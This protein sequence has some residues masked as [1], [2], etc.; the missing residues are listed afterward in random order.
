MKTKLLFICVMTILMIGTSGCNNWACENLGLFCSDSSTPP[1]EFNTGKDISSAQSIVGKS[2]K[3]IKNATGDISKETQAIKKE[4]DQTKGKIPAA[5]KKEI[6]THLDKINKSSNTISEKTQDINKSVA[7]LNG[8]NSLLNNAG[9]KIGTIESALKK[10]TKER[11]AAIIA[12]DEAESDRDSA[13]HDAL[14]WLILASIV[15]VGA[16]GVFGFMYQSKMCLTLSAICIVI[17][18]LAIFLETFFI[19]FAIGGGCIL[20]ALVGF[21]IYNIYI[22]NRA[23]SE[24]INTVELTKEALPLSKKVELFGENGQ[25]GAMD[26]I[27]SPKTM[28]MVSKEKSKMSSLWKYAK[29]KKE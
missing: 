27:Q 3:E 12:R 22:K 19:Y 1:P 9:K 24:V 11:N 23:F 6:D 7:E 15:G 4:I 16:L 13:L 10:I 28:Q 25:T 2:T 8:A 29:N 26:T 18:S 20:A 5:L 17:L 21:M 14:R